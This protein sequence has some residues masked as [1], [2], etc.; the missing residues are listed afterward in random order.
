VSAQSEHPADSRT[1]AIPHTING[2]GDALTG[3]QRARF[4]GEVLAAEASA[5][6][7]V[8]GRWWKT[9]ML[10]Q[11]RGAATSRANAA[12]GRRLVAIDDLAARLENRAS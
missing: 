8:M 12:A 5:V 9:A 4:Y 10:D 3:E 2:I 11:A 7:G 1:P 6:P